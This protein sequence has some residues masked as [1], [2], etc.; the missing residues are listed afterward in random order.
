MQ[1]AI[2]SN[3]SYL[4]VSQTRSW[5]SGVNFLNEGPSKPKNT[6]DFLP[7]VNDII[8]VVW[9]IMRNIMASSDNGEYGTIFINSHTA[10]PIYTTLNEM[11]WKQG[12]TAIQ[13]DNSTAVGIATK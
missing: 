9:K 10:V 1:L 12:P 13:V 2:S 8:L 5:A 11:G 7:I 3:A 4:S 6:E